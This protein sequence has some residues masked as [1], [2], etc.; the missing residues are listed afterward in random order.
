M[1]KFKSFLHI[2]EQVA[3]MALMLVPGIPAPIAMIAG[4]AIQEAQQI[5]GAS[6]ADKKQHVLNIAQAAG[7]SADTMSALDNGIDTAISV[8]H[9]YEAKHL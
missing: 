5:P 4:K 9:V 3:P 8:A 6:N 7:A 1:S 2:L